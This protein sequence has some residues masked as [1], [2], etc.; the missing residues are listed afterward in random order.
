VDIKAATLFM[1]IITPA[2]D[3]VPPNFSAYSPHPGAAE[4]KTMFQL[5][6]MRLL[7]VET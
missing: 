7:R 4:M 3:A 2:N 5:V 6:M 1:P